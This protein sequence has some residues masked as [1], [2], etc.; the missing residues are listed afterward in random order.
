MENYVITDACTLSAE[1]R[2]QKEIEQLKALISARRQKAQATERY[3]RMF[4]ECMPLEKLQ[5][6]QRHLKRTIDSLWD[7]HCELGHLK[8]PPPLQ[9][10][11]FN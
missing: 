11:M 3:L 5:M 7:M 6:L 10:L 9:L 2:R 4:G 8:Y 1:S